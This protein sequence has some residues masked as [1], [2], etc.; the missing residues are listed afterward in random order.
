MFATETNDFQTLSHFLGLPTPKEWL[1]RAVIE[2]PLLLVD[3]AHCERKAAVTAI[4]FM[5][6][7]PE[8]AELVRVMS[9]LAREEL[10]HFEK[11]IQLLK[12]KNIKFGPLKPSS[13]A[14]KLH[15][16]VTKNAGHARLS[17]QLIIGAIIEARSCERFQLLA[18]AITDSALSRFYLSLAKSE[19]RHFE[20]YL[21]LATLYENDITTRVKLFLDIENE[22]I[23]SYDT[24]F[25]FHSGIPI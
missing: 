4:N 15:Q 23:A 16:A 25:R 12:K 5:S 20:E 7:Y 10:L 11:V 24:T 2:L 9:P 19:A 22:T 13:Y 18:A 8:K 1:D 6:K 21:R 17:D 14:T 3:H